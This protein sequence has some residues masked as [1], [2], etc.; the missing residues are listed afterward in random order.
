MIRYPNVVN[1]LKSQPSGCLC[2]HLNIT[3]SPPNIRSWLNN[4]ELRIEN[5]KSI[6]SKAII[7]PREFQPPD[8]LCEITG[9]QLDRIQQDQT[10]LILVFFPSPAGYS[11]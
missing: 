5:Q 7:I 11:F 2:K 1:A 3:G 4:Q 6:I 8:E 9:V 10:S